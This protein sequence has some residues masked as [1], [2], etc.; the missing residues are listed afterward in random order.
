MANKNQQ[1]KRREQKAIV[2]TGGLVSSNPKLNMAMRVLYNRGGN[3]QTS[4]M[5]IHEPLDPSRP[6]SF[7]NHSYME[8]RK[9]GGQ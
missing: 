9:P 5:T 3:G 7:R 2:G 6:F 4:S 1:K 8:Y